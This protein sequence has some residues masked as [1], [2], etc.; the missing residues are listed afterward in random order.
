MKLEVKIGLRWQLHLLFWLA[1]LALETYFEF[2]WI[3]TSFKDL[4]Y[5]RTFFL[6]F[7]AELSLLPHKIAL[8]YTIFWILANKEKVLQSWLISILLI[9]S[10]FGIAILF[11]RLIVVYWAL[12]VLYAEAIEVQA[13]FELNRINTTIGDLLF[14]VG[15]ATAVKQFRNQQRSKE[16]ER[17]LTKEKL[18]AELRFLQNQTN[19]HFL[20]NTLNNI[21]ALARKKADETPEVIMKLAQLLRFMLYECK[22]ESIALH[23]EIKVIDDYISLEKIRYQNKLQISFKKE[24]DNENEEIAPLILLPFVENAFTHGASESRFGAYIS[25]VLSVKNGILEFSIINSKEESGSEGKQGIG[26]ANIRRQLELIYKNFDL[27]V[28]QEED[29]FVVRLYIDLRGKEAR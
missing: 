21:Y 27:E 10:A 17:N 2:A 15:L 1:Y 5:L 22:R 7:F 11:Q 20:F 18:E 28:A 29:K 25:I 8:T 24:V 6:A 13:I 12:P 9:M 3:R 16:Y 26:L 19:P 23:E 4:P 14:V